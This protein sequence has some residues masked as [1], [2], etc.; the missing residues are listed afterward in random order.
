MHSNCSRYVIA[1]NG[2]IYNT[3]ELRSTLQKKGVSFR[4]H[5]D[6][7]AILES[8]ALHGIEATT[9]KL[10]GMF[11]FAVW[12]RKEQELWLARD[13]LGIKPL[14]W[15]LT[16]N[17]T[18]IFGSE[19]K[20]L[21]AHPECPTEIDRDAVAG[22]MRHNYISG[23]RT[24]YKNVHKLQ[25][26]QIL[27]YSASLGAPIIQQFW[28]LEKAFTNGIAYPFEGSDDDAVD[29]LEELLK[30]TIGRS[31]IAD[32]PLGA[33]LSG[34]ID[35]STVAALMQAQRSEPVKTFSIGFETEAHN[36]AQY[37]AK[38]AKHLGSDHTEVYVNGQDALDVVPKLPDMFDEPFA[39]SS[40]IPTYL[41]SS[42]TKKHVTVAL[43]GDGGDELFA[44]YERYLTAQRIMNKSGNIPAPLRSI[45]ANSISALSPASWDAIAN[46]LPTSKRPDNT[47]DRAHKLA[48]ILKG[49]PD[50][51]FRSLISHWDSPDNI[52]IGGNEPKGVI[53]DQSFASK[54]PDFITRMQYMDSA[55][56]LTDDILTKIDRASMFDALEARVPLLDHRIIEFA[57]TLPQHM[58]VRNGQGK[59]ILRQVLEKYVPQH[60]FDR[61]KMGFGVPLDRWLRGPL[62]DWAEDLLSQETFERHGL[63]HRAPVLQKWQQH[64][65]GQANYQYLLWDVLMLHAWANKHK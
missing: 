39:D 49:E 46:L 13:R 2:E 1:Y 10:I 24:I 18:L 34:G 60:L 5:S 35:S 4:G 48:A 54:I 53:W 30:D 23:P 43:S 25:S 50:D 59:W 12:D 36:E 58:K 55:T 27:R 61:P 65:S 8:C 15:T 41:L 45:L 56:Y 32:V 57:A 40:Q 19:L 9:K 47:G 44:G 17:G 3:N 33:F 14:Y 11:A 31:M 28:N 20:A 29:T 22:F 37:A 16:P 51:I 64:I 6:T 42:L 62:R 7:E 38:V 26:G 21:R 63:L 52:V